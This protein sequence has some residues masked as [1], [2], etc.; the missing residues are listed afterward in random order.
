[1]PT[2][3]IA[4]R[5]GHRVSLLIGS[6]V[7]VV[8]M[9]FCWFGQGV[10]ELLA[11]SVLIA[12][13]DAFRSGANEALLYRTCAALNRKDEFLR[14]TART[15]AAGLIALVALTLGGGVVVQHWGFAAGWAAETCLCLVGAA[16][17]WAFS[18]PPPARRS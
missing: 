8:G 1:M 14:I 10:P 16:L 17:A 4:D 3:W 2:G 13:G 15:R 7:Q 11:A 5:F 18:E 9:L 12:L 6:I